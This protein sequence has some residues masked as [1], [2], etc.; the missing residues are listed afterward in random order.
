MRDKESMEGSKLLIKG[1]LQ[2]VKAF[3]ELM[4]GE[5]AAV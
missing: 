5:G 2:I 4:G 1:T 3:K